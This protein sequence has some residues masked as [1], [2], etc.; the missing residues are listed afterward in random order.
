MSSTYS[1][2][3]YGLQIYKGT[4]IRAKLPYS[5][6]EFLSPPY[7]IAYKSLANGTIRTKIDHLLTPN[8]KLNKQLFEVLRSEVEKIGQQLNVN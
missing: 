7:E 4:E 8:S 2:T 3:A 6:V 5:L 1:T